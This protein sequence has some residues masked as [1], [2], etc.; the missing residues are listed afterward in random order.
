MR[1]RHPLAM[2]RKRTI[3]CSLMHLPATFLTGGDAI[4]HATH[5]T[6]CPISCFSPTPQTDCLLI[7][8]I[9]ILCEGAAFGRANKFRN[10][11]C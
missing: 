4:T 3:A 2:G 8:L 5:A 6:V 7:L 9:S 10:G 1:K 11:S